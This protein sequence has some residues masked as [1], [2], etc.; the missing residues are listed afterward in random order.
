MRQAGPE[1]AGQQG[2]GTCPDIECAAGEQA[3]LTVQKQLGLFHKRRCAWRQRHDQSRPGPPQAGWQGVKT[4][5]WWGLYHTGESAKSTHL[6]SVSLDVPCRAGKLLSW[7]SLGLFGPFPP[8]TPGSP[9]ASPDHPS[10]VSKEE[11]NYL[12]LFVYSLSWYQ[13]PERPVVGKPGV[14][15][16]ALVLVPIH[17]AFPLLNKGPRPLPEPEPSFC[18]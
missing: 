8:G 16:G 2:L 15:V 10:F 14:G 5:S 1:E 13:E 11:G 18:K 17:W 12:G 3:P 6:A 4:C 9:H 7:S